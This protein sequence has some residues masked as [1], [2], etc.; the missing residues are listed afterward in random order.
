MTTLTAAWTRSRQERLAFASSSRSLRPHCPHHLKEGAYRQCAVKRF[1]MCREGHPPLSNVTRSDHFLFSLAE[2]PRPWRTHARACEGALCNT[3]SELSQSCRR[4][5][6]DAA[7][8][9][10]E[11]GTSCISGVHAHNQTH[12]AARLV[13]LSLR[14]RFLRPLSAIRCPRGISVCRSGGAAASS[15]RRRQPPPHRL[16]RP[17]RPPPPH[18]LRRRR[19][20]RRRPLP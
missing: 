3:K 18:R 2:L 9:L 17:Q 14:W 16:Y 1:D 10:R 12:T 8:R 15:R 7:A 20:R 4:C 13:Q 5:A 11:A 19:R 6:G